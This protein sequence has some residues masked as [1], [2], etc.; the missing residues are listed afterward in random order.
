M[1]E[2]YADVVRRIAAYTN[3]ESIYHL[4]QLVRKESEYQAV[5]SEREMMKFELDEITNDILFRLSYYV[6]GEP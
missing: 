5:E 1:A 6:H 3:R 4:C 2:T